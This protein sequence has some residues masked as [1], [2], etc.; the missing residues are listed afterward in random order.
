[1][2]KCDILKEE[3][4]RFAF[5]HQITKQSKENFHVV[6]SPMIKYRTK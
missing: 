2:Y 5:D 3:H 1:M 6:D 4:N